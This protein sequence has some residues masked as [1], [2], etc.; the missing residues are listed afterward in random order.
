MPRK[1]KMSKKPKKIPPKKKF[2]ISIFWEFFWVI[3][4]A[5][6]K[7]LI[8]DQN[9]WKYRKAVSR[10]TSRHHLSFN[11]MV[12]STTSA[13]FYFPSFHFRFTKMRFSIIGKNSKILFSSNNRNIF[14][15][16]FSNLYCILKF[17]LEGVVIWRSKPQN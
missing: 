8:F 14:S 16:I 7:N 10:F 6:H 11:L 15:L 5:K 1:Q 17:N 12:L 4:S 9:S 13:N 3:F 2:E